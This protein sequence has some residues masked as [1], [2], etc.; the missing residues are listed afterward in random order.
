M[1]TSRTFF[2]QYILFYFIVFYSRSGFGSGTH[3]QTVIL[4][5]PRLTDC[6]SFEN[7]TGVKRVYRVSE[8]SVK[9]FRLFW[10]E[11]V[12]KEQWSHLS[13]ICSEFNYGQ[14]YA[15]DVRYEQNNLGRCFNWSWFQRESLII[16][17]YPLLFFFTEGKQLSVIREKKELSGSSTSLNSI[18]KQNKLLSRM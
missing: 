2:V 8:T 17:L 4:R 10:H 12:T 7:R 6:R 11:T 5:K 1:I 9:S 3:F 14:E 18:G 15:V 13:Y 16:L